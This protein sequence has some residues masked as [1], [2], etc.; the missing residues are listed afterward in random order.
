MAKLK[1][2]VQVR[3]ISI[4]VKKFVSRV[5]TCADPLQQ[6]PYFLA[7][8][9]YFRLVHQLQHNIGIHERNGGGSVRFFAH[10]D[11]AQK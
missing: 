3:F 10:D 11:V 4:P 7:K 8:G 1:N 6:R 9:I 2:N 5:E